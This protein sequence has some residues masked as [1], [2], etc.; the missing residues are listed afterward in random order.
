MV[1]PLFVF[2]HMVIGKCL[3]WSP[4]QWYVSASFSGGLYAADWDSCSWNNCSLTPGGL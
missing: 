2:L 1:V 3:N 4:S